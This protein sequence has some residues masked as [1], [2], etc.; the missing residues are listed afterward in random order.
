MHPGETIAT[1]APTVCPTCQ[2]SVL[3]LVV[4]HSAAGHYIG[5]RCSCSSSYSRES[6]YYPSEAA[7][8]GALAERSFGRGGVVA[9]DVS[10]YWAD[11]S[12]DRDGVVARILTGELPARDLEDV[13]PA[14]LSYAEVKA[15][16][17]SQTPLL[18]AMRQL[19]ARKAHFV[20]RVLGTLPADGI[21]DGEVTPLSG[22]SRRFRVT[23]LHT[24]GPWVF[25]RYLPG[26]P[27]TRVFDLTVEATSAEAA[28]EV[29]FEITNS[30]LPD[31]VHCDPRYADDV[32]AYR[33]AAGR[34][35]SVGDVLLIRRLWRWR[36]TAWACAWVGF[37]QLR[38]PPSF[39]DGR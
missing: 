36:K 35:M 38:R 17:A 13:E 9:R 25:H 31:E 3:P 23:V 24:S 6:D 29:V 20:A 21:G 19:R 10:V 18:G 33:T 5:T 34:S 15:V 7:A 16:A 14:T 39:T 2:V 12:A 8:E 11:Q 27:L 30:Y 4:L 22:R 1:G 37:T 26:D 28:A 32:A